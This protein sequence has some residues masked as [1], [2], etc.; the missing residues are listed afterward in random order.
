MR[1]FVTIGPR[2]L[3]VELGPDCLRLDGDEI[4]AD[5]MEMDGTEVLSLLLG[6]RSH[7][8]LGARRGPGEWSLY[9]SGRH[10]RAHVVDERTRAI[11]EMT[12]NRE[13]ARGPGTLRAPMPGLVVKVEVQEGDEVFPGQGLVIVEAMKMENELK[14]EAQAQVGKVLVGPGDTVEKDQILIEFQ[15]Q[16]EPSK[17]G[18]GD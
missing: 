15:A 14:A 2:Q 9:M 1:Y 3:E 8:I 5:L 7:R 10:L 12:G 17:G 4:S 16:G 11:R 18:P 13:V 6:T